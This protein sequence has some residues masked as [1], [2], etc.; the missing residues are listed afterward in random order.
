MDYWL[1]SSL[2]HSKHEFTA[3]K[4]QICCAMLRHCQRIAKTQTTQARQKIAQ[5]EVAAAGEVA[6][7]AGFSLKSP[8]ICRT[9]VLI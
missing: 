1:L 9:P 3:R 5:L 4:G 6:S 7:K 8:L 2:N